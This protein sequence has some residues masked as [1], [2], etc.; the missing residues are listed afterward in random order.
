[1]IQTS[2]YKTIPQLFTVHY[3]DLED[4]KNCMHLIQNLN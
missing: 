4:I 3:L 2:A 1:M